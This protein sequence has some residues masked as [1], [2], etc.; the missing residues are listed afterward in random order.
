MKMFKFVTIIALIL[1]LLA[2]CSKP[3]MP[4][5]QGAMTPVTST[6]TIS[7]DI[8]AYLDDVEFQTHRQITSEQ[9]QLMLAWI[10]KTPIK[11]LDKAVTNQ[12][13]HEFD[14][15]KKRLL[16]E[17]E[18][19]TGQKWPKYT[20]NVYNKK[21]GNIDRKIGSNYDAHHLVELS[22]GGA[23]EWWNMHPA[24]FPDEHQGGIHRKGSP[25]S[26]LFSEDLD[27]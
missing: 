8:Q 18:Q 13:R 5:T 16:S 12:H 11:K 25:A 14:G 9:K 3:P 17:W 7:P 27:N 2:G 22:Y 20:E 6:S 4:I 26:I 23:N 10:A 24:K 1:G 21:S 19:H 15:V